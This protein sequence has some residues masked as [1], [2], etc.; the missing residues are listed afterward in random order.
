MAAA[1]ERRLTG[2]GASAPPRASLRELAWALPKMRRNPLMVWQH[3]YDTYGPVVC[4]PGL[5]RFDTYYLFGPE[6]NRF[7]MLDRE[8]VF[9]AR[10]SWTLI[11]GRIFPNGLLL[12]DGED[13][14]HHRKIMHAAFTTQAL[15]EYAARMNPLIE[16]GLAAWRVPGERF[17]AF[18]AFKELTLHLATRIFLGLDLPPTAEH[19]LQR[20]FEATVAA[21]MS[22][23]RVDH[24]R[25]EFGR[26]LAG[27]Q[28]MIRLFGAFV[29]EKRRGDGRDMFS[30]LC[31]AETEDGRRYADAEI[32]D[33]LIFLMM[34][35][36]DT[37]TSVL[38][39]LVYELAKHPNW[40]DRVRTEC[41]VLGQEHLPYER[42]DELTDVRLV[43][44]ETLRR[45]P[46]LSTIPRVS[47]R[48]FEFA[49]LSHPREPDG[50]RGA[51]PYALHDGVVERA[52]TIRPGALRAGARGAQAAHPRVGAFQRRRPHVPGRALRGDADP[53]GA[54]P[55]RSEVP[56]E[57]ARRLHDAGPASADLEAPRRTAAPARGERVGGPPTERPLSVGRSASP[58]LENGGVPGDVVGDG[59][60]GELSLAARCFD[61]KR[62]PAGLQHADIRDLFVVR[63]VPVENELLDV[64]IGAVDRYLHFL[65]VL[66]S[67]T[68]G[69]LEL[70]ALVGGFERLLGEDGPLVFRLAPMN[71][72]NPTTRPITVARLLIL[73]LPL[74]SVDA[75]CPFGG[76]RS[77]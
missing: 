45:Y 5:G 1:A 24:P 57:R 39:S 41:S 35:A 54:A 64:H 49:R 25:L 53:P 19:E 52:R 63:V 33:H 20:A 58:D 59:C 38:T 26:G 75:E 48:D 70:G 22:L 7:L 15:Q 72:R 13:H 68:T 27:R 3:Y 51:A 31:R 11:M 6:A 8:N 66:I 30:L 65:D 42:M 4:Q 17:L 46:P 77:Q 16:E 37:T 60:P 71:R 40:Q 61:G 69:A 73:T 2:K 18:D 28:Y 21:A 74:L 62:R 56:L 10:R 12:R 47:T 23:L 32:V 14:R 50:L 29:E 36:H 67:A 55:A 76:R 9:S 34:A 43:L 44:N